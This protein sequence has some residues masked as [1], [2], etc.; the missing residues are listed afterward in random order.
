[1]EGET[2]KCKGR[3]RERRYER[4][5]WSEAD[6]VIWH[7]FTR[8]IYEWSRLSEAE[9]KHRIGPKHKDTEWTD[10][11]GILTSEKHRKNMTY[12][13]RYTTVDHDKTDNQPN[14]DVGYDDTVFVEVIANDT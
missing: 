11:M 6:Y 10:N 9:I 1:M 7:W 8:T 14:A 5:A 4:F 3:L 2:K 12:C 13:Q